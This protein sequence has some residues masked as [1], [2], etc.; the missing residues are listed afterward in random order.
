MYPSKVVATA[1]VTFWIQ[2][3]RFLH[4]RELARLSPVCKSGRRAIIETAASSVIKLRYTDYVV[5]SNT[6]WF[7]EWLRRSSDQLRYLE[8]REFP[9]SDLV[10]LLRLIGK[11]GWTSSSSVL[12]SVEDL[13]IEIRD[14]RAAF[15]ES[16]HLFCPNLCFLELLY[17]T[18]VDWSAVTVSAPKLETCVV[19][20]CHLADAVPA[21]MPGDADELLH[22]GRV[23]DENEKILMDPSLRDS[24]I[25]LIEGKFLTALH[26]GELAR[27][28]LARPELRP[29]RPIS[30]LLPLY[31]PLETSIR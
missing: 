20:A 10:A 3:L 5:L 29:D 22:L 14:N 24:P 4:V 11:G 18:N 15:S 2:I 23:N 17:T 9:A 12:E 16:L 13:R 31:V 26:H 6:E 8:L 27:K 30:L 25:K 28:W 21:S 1:S 19:T 7:N